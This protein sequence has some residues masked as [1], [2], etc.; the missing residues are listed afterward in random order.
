VGAKRETQNPDLEIDG[1][2]LGGTADMYPGLVA[3]RL[4]LRTKKG[5]KCLNSS[6][7]EIFPRR[8]GFVPCTTKLS[9]FKIRA[10]TCRSIDFDNSRV[11]ASS[12]RYAHNGND[13][14]CHRGRFPLSLQAHARDEV[15]REDATS[16]SVLVFAPR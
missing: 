15:G 4:E 16:L 3:V 12:A 10:R 1:R 2:R 11:F 7:L 5:A 14:K 13:R 6:W 8:R 9:R